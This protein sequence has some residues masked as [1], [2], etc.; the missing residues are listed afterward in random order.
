MSAQRSQQSHAGTPRMPNATPNM[1]NATPI[2]RQLNATPRMSQASPLPGNMATHMGNQMMMHNGVPMNQ[3]SQQQMQ[4]M[5]H[6]QQQQQHQARLQQQ[7]QH[8]AMAMNPEMAR[9]HLIRQQQA[10]QQAQAQAQG[11]SPQQA[12]MMRGQY[13]QQLMMI[14]QNQMQGGMNGAFMNGQAMGNPQMQANGQMHGMPQGMQGQPMTQ[15]QMIHQRMTQKMQQW[16]EASVAKGMGQLNAQFGGN[17]P[18]EAVDNLRQQ[19]KAGAQQMRQTWLARQAHAQQV[20]MQQGALQQG[21][22]GPGGQVNM[23][24]GQR[25]QGM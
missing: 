17:P 16:Y 5:I 23:G 9:M 18:K 24:M 12:Q 7:Q 21:M 10:Q 13:N 11:M 22:V 14:Q 2:N 4:H 25:M 3:L 6:L 19:A 1:P 15:N 20:A 8:A